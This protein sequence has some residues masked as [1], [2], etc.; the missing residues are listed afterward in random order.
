[1]LLLLL[2]WLLMV[3]CV[4]LVLSAIAR[5]PPSQPCRSCVDVCQLMHPQLTVGLGLGRHH[6]IPQLLF[7]LL[8][9]GRGQQQ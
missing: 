3:P 9:R 7:A 2:L 4:L 8:C 1:M 6:G 5:H